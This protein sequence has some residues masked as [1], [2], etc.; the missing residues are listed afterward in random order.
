MYNLL[1]KPYSALCQWI[2]LYIHYFDFKF[3]YF[4]DFPN[5]ITLKESLAKKLRLNFKFS[6]IKRQIYIT[7]WIHLGIKKVM[8]NGWKMDGK[9]FMRCYNIA[10]KF[11]DEFNANFALLYC[12]GYRSIKIDTFISKM[13]RK[14][15]R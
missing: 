13:W 10:L 15:I 9:T 2:V 5:Q 11:W 14:T 4:L 8:E 7:L 1:K 3:S 12:S 6:L